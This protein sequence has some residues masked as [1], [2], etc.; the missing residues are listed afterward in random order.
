MEIYSGARL[1]SHG[2][3]F[4]I[5]FAYAQ[6]ECRKMSNH[7]EADSNASI[8]A[9][10]AELDKAFPSLIEVRHA[11]AHSAA[12]TFSPA[13]QRKHRFITP[14]DTSVFIS[15]SLFG[16]DFVYT[17]NGQQLSFPITAEAAA[18][19]RTIAELALSAF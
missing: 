12:Q 19:I 13:D 14:N 6:G 5:D 3:S 16:K 11:V 1:R 10:I 8:N 2:L 7:I 17:R 18:S 4:S 15:S 9:A